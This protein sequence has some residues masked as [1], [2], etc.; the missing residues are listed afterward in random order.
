M[1]PLAASRGIGALDQCPCAPNSVAET[2]HCELSAPHGG[3]CRIH[4]AR[5][6][7]RALPSALPSCSYTSNAFPG[8]YVPT[9][10]DNYSA[11]VIVQDRPLNLSLWDTAGACS[12]LARCGF[13]PSCR[14]FLNP[15]APSFLAAGQEDYDRVRPLSYPGT[16][17]F[18][19]CFSLIKCA[20]V[21]IVSLS[22]HSSLA[23]PAPHPPISPLP[24]SVV[25]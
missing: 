19:Y 14:L 7:Q 18:L 8:E 3:R 6:F 2:P 23:H 9:I 24:Q 17:V 16:N 10:F 5:S 15:R 12:V 11:Q 13:A 4:H 25:V 20:R 22:S 1:V 21:E